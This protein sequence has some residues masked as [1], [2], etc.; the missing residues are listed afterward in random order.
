MASLLHEAIRTNYARVHECAY[1]YSELVKRPESMN[2]SDWDC[3]SDSVK[4]T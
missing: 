1:A 4:V 2:V 3:L